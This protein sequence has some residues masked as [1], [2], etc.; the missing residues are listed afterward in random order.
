MEMPRLPSTVKRPSPHTATCNRAEVMKCD[1][2][3]D[4]CR[5]S[6]LVKT[7]CTSRSAK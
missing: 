2:L 3:S 1:G 4:S 5:R 7:A 6:R